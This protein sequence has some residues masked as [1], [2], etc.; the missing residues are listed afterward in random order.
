MRNLDLNARPILNGKVNFPVCLAPMV[1]L[2]HVGFRRMV[3]EYL[4]EGAV[5]IWPTEML[6]SRRI[7]K[8]DLKRV[9]ETKQGVRAPRLPGNAR[10]R[11]GFADHQL[12][13]SD[14]SIRTPGC[15]WPI[16]PMTAVNASSDCLGKR[17]GHLCRAM[18]LVFPGQSSRVNF[19]SR[20]AC[21]LRI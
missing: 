14:S 8:E 12:P 19:P 1:G 13:V 16:V 6:N 18:R 10:A 4:P 9:P 15:S 3:R 2:T 21:W 11:P 7:P 17:S 5:T 20:L